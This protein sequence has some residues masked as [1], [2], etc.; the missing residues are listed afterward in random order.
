MLTDSKLI[1]TADLYFLIKI[2]LKYPINCL[3]SR[4]GN[5]K[6]NYFKIRRPKESLLHNA[7]NGK[8]PSHGASVKKV[9]LF[10]GSDNRTYI[11]NEFLS[12]YLHKY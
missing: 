3:M 8:I 12:T 9:H 11:A 7:T 6:E 5:K 2:K 10:A 4:R 1:E